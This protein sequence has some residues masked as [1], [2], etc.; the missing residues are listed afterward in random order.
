MSY[1]SNEPSFLDIGPDSPQPEEPSISI[2]S[3][4]YEHTVSYGSG[5]AGGPEAIL[6]ASSQV[7]F[8]DD[9][10]RTELCFSKGIATLPP[11]DVAGMVGMQVL[12]AVEREVDEQLDRGRFVVTIGGEHTVSYAPIKSHLKKYPNLTLLQFDAHADLRHEFQG[13]QYSHACVIARV[14]EIMSPQSIVQVGIR[15]LSREEY[16]FIGLHGITTLYA[17]GIRSGAYGADWQDRIAAVVGRDVY[18]TLD[19]DALDPSIMPATGTPEPN[20]LLYHEIVDTIRAIVDAGKRIVG[21]DVVELAPIRGLHHPDLTTARLIYKILN[22]AFVKQLQG[23]EIPQDTSPQ[24]LDGDIEV[25][26]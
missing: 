1:N 14:A 6:R 17:R 16:R 10:T 24:L 18:V 23:E 2:I 13:T 5:T 21:F 25:G 26:K 19:V 4:P 12:D 3:V 15:A 20:G 11:V 9:E 22:L 8:F 7:E